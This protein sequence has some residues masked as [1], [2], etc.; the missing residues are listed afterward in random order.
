MKNSTIQWMIKELIEKM[1][2]S[3]QDNAQEELQG[4]VSKEPPGS[5]AYERERRKS[6]MKTGLYFGT[7]IQAK[8]ALHLIRC[9]LSSEGK[10]AP[11]VL[12]DALEQELW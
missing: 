10:K 12:L 4:P 2:A 6:F 8:H 9:G 11:K 1:E 5:D 7:F 3:R